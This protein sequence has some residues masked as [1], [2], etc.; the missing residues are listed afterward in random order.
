[1]VTLGA[2]DYV[3]FK[4]L[5]RSLSASINSE[6][7]YAATVA[8]VERVK[9]YERQ[10]ELEKLSGGSVAEGLQQAYAAT[11][12]VLRPGDK[13]HPPKQIIPLIPP[14]LS[15]FPP[16]QPYGRFGEDRVAFLR[17]YDQLG[18]ENVAFPDEYAEEDKKETEQ[19]K[20][21]VKQDWNPGEPP[22]SS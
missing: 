20:Q 16:K 9:M 8:L 17:E 22:Q 5:S 18:K 2:I 21:S 11:D 13:D 7:Y 1:M 4:H 12:R 10:L 15:K 19:D 14:D 6:E 3:E